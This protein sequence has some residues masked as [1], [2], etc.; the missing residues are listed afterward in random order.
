MSQSWYCQKPVS[1]VSSCY[2]ARNTF[3]LLNI[4]YFIKNI[5]GSLSIT[6][7]LRALLCCPRNS[8]T[9]DISRS[10]NLKWCDYP[11]VAS[12]IYAKKNR[13]AAWTSYH[14]TTTAG[15]TTLPRGK[16]MFY[17]IL[18]R[19]IIM[20]ASSLLPDETVTRFINTQFFS[21]APSST[22]QPS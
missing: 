22:K 9:S 1:V 18:A 10:V 12:Q 20:H 21:P 4:S 3:S 6:W 7:L 2:W 14:V 8:R 13:V 5:G 11:L 15:P 16:T 17:S 19:S